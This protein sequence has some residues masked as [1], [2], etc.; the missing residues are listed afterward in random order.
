MLV[1]VSVKAEEDKDEIICSAARE[2]SALRRKTALLPILAS[3]RFHDV[4]RR[5][6]FHL[7]SLLEPFLSSSPLTSTR[8]HLKTSLNPP[9]LHDTIQLQVG[10]CLQTGTP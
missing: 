9:T 2:Q 1:L 3:R 8:S 10:C 4:E 6:P 7:D 5:S